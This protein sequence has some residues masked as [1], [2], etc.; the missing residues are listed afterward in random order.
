MFFSIQIF[1]LIVDVIET[2]L[3]EKEGIRDM[4][5]EYPIVIIALMV[6][7]IIGYFSNRNKVQAIISILWGIILVSYITYGILIL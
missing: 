4:P 6:L 3:L 5:F 7:S 1:T 2:S